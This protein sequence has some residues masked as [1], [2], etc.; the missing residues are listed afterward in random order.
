MFSKQMI[1]VSDPVG[2][3]LCECVKLKSIR[4]GLMVGEPTVTDVKCINSDPK[5]N[6][7]MRF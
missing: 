3:G 7:Y 6:G 1:Y 5:Q 2:T 4:S